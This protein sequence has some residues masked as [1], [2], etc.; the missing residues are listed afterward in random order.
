[1]SQPSAETT[2]TELARIKERLDELVETRFLQGKN[3]YYLSALGND[4]G[5]DK[6]AIQE[7]FGLTLLEFIQKHTK[8]QTNRFGAHNN[9]YG[10]IPDGVDPHDVI[11]ERPRRR[12]KKG[13]WA[14][15]IYADGTE[16]TTH[17]LNLSTLHF[18]TTEEAARAG[19]GAILPIDAKYQVCWSDPQKQDL[20]HER[21]EQWLNDNNLTPDPFYEVRFSSGS[22]TLLE[23][24]ISSLSAEQM[25]R[26]SLPLDV[27][28][29]LF[30]RRT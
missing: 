9:V 13:F 7:K 16:P 25:Q 2:D 12:F 29:A 4:L 21:I 26:V 3:I 17:Y 23:N 28:A 27:V 30:K 24:I 11:P 22:E 15:F 19:G 10:I 5:S 20:L 6:S 18:D 8:Y 1:M 14:A